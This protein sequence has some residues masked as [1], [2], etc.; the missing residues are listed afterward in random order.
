M[1]IEDLIIARMKKRGKSKVSDIVSET[2]FS[3]VYVSRI[4][5]K[6]RR[7]GKVELIGK[8]NL[9]HYVLAKS[10]NIANAR[11]KLLRTQRTFNNIGLSEDLVFDEIRKDTGIFVD[12][13]KNIFII[14]Q[15]AFTEMVNNA[16]EHS[17]SKKV[18]TSFV[19]DKEG[20][21]FEVRDFGVGIFNNIKKEKKLRDSLEAIQILIKGK[22]TTAPK[23]HS[24]EGIFFTSKVSDILTIKS[25]GKTL[26]F[27]NSLKDFFIRDSKGFKGTQVTFFISAKSKIKLESVFQKYTEDSLDFRKT[28][29][30]IRLYKLD[31][32][33]IS[34]SQARRVVAG[35]DKFKSVVL[36]FD[37]VETV[38]QGFAD[39]IFRV[40]Q[41]NNPKIKISYINANENIDFM[42]KRA[43]GE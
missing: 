40:W 26:I 37:K 29:V 13:P 1:Q 19:R 36:D 43:L 30:A 14:L 4:F 32:I 2:G 7:E 12:A 42:I 24:G 39:E 3:R 16:I 5:S 18:E 17:K 27:D 33:Y 31:T 20:Y 10:K 28:E 11:K 38:G 25:F 35:L 22:Q 21:K 34:R 8:T 23:A 15:Y 9:A 41:S 6:L